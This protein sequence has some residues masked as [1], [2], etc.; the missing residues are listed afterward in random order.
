MY[1]IGELAERFGISRSTLLYYDRI[2]LLSPS[3]RSGAG[4]RLYSVA[5]RQ[6]L[7]AIRSY[8]RAGLGVEDIRSILA[9]GDDASTA[10]LQRRLR[11]VGREMAALRSQQRVLAGMLRVR[12]EDPPRTSVD[13]DMFVAMLRAAGMDDQAMGRLHAEFELREPQAHHAFLLSLGISENEALLIRR[14]SAGGDSEEETA[15]RDR[16]SA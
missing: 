13:K 4:Y 15:A 2:G 5:D 16:G 6:R 10:L 7:D 14:W 8:R 3:L 9:C 11:E 1:R 12:G